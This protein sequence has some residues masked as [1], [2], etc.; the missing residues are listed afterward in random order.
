MRGGG[1]TAA[2]PRSDVRG[3]VNRHERREWRSERREARAQNP[4]MRGTRHRA[5]RRT[6][7]LVDGAVLVLRHRLSTRREVGATIE[8]LQ[9]LGIEVLGTVLNGIDTRSDAYY[10]YY[11]YYYRSGYAN[12]RDPAWTPSRQERRRARREAKEQ[13]RVGS[14]AGASGGGPHRTTARGPRHA[15]DP[16]GRRFI[17]DRP[18]EPPRG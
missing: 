18:G 9:T 5:G 4:E 17:P 1:V 7:T 16:S 3:T 12:E 10:H 15:S 6:R 8:R 14:A 13:D 11:S 2:L